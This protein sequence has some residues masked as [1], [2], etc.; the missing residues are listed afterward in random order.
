MSNKLAVPLL[1]L[2]AS[3]VGGVALATSS[4][5]HWPWYISRASGLAAFAA[6]SASVILGLMVTTKVAEPRVPRIFSF[7]MH[8]FLS[9]LSLSLTGIHAGALM[10][11]GFVR[12]SPAQVLVPF[13]GGTE[14]FW[15]G[16]GVISAWLAA[17]VTASFWAKKRIGHKAWRRFHYASFGAYVLGLV[18]GLGAGTDTALA[19]VYW[20]YVASAA[21]VAALLVYRVAAPPPAK[22]PARPRPAPAGTT[23]G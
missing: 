10:F 15:T 17:A 20:G 19:P 9:V 7:D 5:S 23:A 12:F 4:G 11:D 22:K 2:A 16:L 3:F 14:P 8:S 6:L 13:L 21:A 1:F 18:H